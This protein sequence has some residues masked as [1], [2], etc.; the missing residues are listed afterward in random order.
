M[1]NERQAPNFPGLRPPSVPFTEVRDRRRAQLQYLDLDL[2]AAR[3]ISGNTAAV[4]PIA[5]N[6]LYIDQDP[7][8]VGFATVRFV[9]NNSVLDTPIA[10]GPGST[11]KVPFTGL[12]IENAAQ[13]GKRLRIIYSVDVDA[14]PG[15]NAQV[16]ING[17]VG[18]QGPRA[19]NGAPVLADLPVLIRDVGTNYGASYK[20]NAALAANTSDTVFSAAA[21]VN[22]AI[23]WEAYAMSENAGA[24]LQSIAWAAHTAPPNNVVVGD[25]LA[26]NDSS[27]LTA[28]L[29]VMFASL[30]TPRFIPAGKG[31]YFTGNVAEAAAMRSA[32]YTLF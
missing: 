17:A 8:N 9:D 24:A 19:I 1:S 25:V 29:F 12:L 14:V 30:R 28:A 11:W 27:A 10:V 13:G 23:V 15:I 26:S 16:V 32:T 2:T 21:N 31:F 3:S 7:Q 4:L 5:G 22:G 6:F 20:S 18:V